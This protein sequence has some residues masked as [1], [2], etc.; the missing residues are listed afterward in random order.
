MQHRQ[1][2]GITPVVLLPVAAFAWDHRRCDHH[3]VFPQLG[4]G[5]VN[6]V[7]TG[8][9]YVAELQRSVAGLAQTPDQLLQCRGGVGECAICCGFPNVTGGGNCDDNRI[10]VH[11]HANKSCRLLHGPSPVPEAPRQTIRRDP[12]SSTHDETGHP[13]RVKTRAIGGWEPRPG[14]VI[15]DTGWFQGP[16]PWLVQ[17][18]TPGLELPFPGL[19]PAGN[20][21]EVSSATRSYRQLPG[22]ILP[23]LVNR[24]VGAHIE[25]RKGAGVAYD[26]V[27]LPRSSN[28]A[29]GFAESARGVSPRA[30]HRSGHEPL[31]SSGSCHPP[32]TAAFR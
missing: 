23:P 18:Q 27:S 12:R 29:C 22:W 24:A 31:D 11:I 20:G 15:T 14:G 3:A 4:E 8:T 5:A 13:F 7:A 25:S 30:A 16:C 32:K 9:G 10:L 1:A 2:G 17:G 19:L 26:P 28:A 21:H 6:T